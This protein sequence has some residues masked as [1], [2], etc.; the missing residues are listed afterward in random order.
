MKILIVEDDFAGRKLLQTMLKSYGECDVA[1]DGVEAVEAC[2]IAIEESAHYDL[3]C[4]DIMMPNKDGHEALKE[5][6]QLEKDLLKGDMKE[7]KA[8]MVTALS[9]PKNVVE[10]LYR[11]G[12][13]SYLV[14]PVTREKIQ[15][16][17]KKLK[18]L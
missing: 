4:M 7:A 16:E 17:L 11:G 5:I 1:F 6:R 2:R 12:A 10:A 13:E 18:L 8:I 15:E 14:K 3:I 9:D